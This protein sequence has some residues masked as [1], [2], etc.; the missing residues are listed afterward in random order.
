M[1]LTS[2]NKLYI[3]KR[4]ASAG[5]KLKNVR[6]SLMRNNQIQL[7]YCKYFLHLK[8]LYEVHKYIFFCMCPILF[9]CYTDIHIFM[10][11]NFIFLGYV[12]HKV[13]CEHSNVY[14]RVGA[15][16]RGSELPTSGS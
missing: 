1:S 15:I 3:K 2:I 10:N 4:G 16:D 14:R 7:R 5:A 13:N 9:K 8:D 6:I 12:F 11:E